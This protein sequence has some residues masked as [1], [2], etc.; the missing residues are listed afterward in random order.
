[1]AILTILKGMMPM[2]IIPSNEIET[3]FSI[4]SLTLG[5]SMSALVSNPVAEPFSH[6]WFSLL[7]P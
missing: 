4:V 6:L 7:L 3:M 5:L 2:D 1:M